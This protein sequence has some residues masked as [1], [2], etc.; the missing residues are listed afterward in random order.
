HKLMAHAFAFIFIVPPGGPAWRGPLRGPYLP[1]PLLTGFV[2]T[3]DRIPRIIGQLIH[4]KHIFHPPNKLSIGL[5]REAPRPYNPRAN[6]IFFNACRTV[7]V[8][9]EATKPKT[10]S[11]SANNCK[12]QWS[13]PS[14]G[15]L[16]AKYSAQEICSGCAMS[17]VL[18]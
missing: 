15:S 4:L 17:K 8:L 3:D 9:S 14:G 1:K 13:R 10:T 16:H 6:V 12:V 18:T 7:S 11:S 5:G 2:K